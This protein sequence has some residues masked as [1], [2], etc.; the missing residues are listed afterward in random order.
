MVTF[1]RIPYATAAKR[2]RVQDAIV[3][4]GLAL[5]LLIG[6]FLITRVIH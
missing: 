1:T 4:T 3:D 6:I 5:L 2:S